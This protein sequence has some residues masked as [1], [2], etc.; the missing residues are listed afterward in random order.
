MDRVQNQVTS[1][2]SDLKEQI[3]QA[4]QEVKTELRTEFKAVLYKKA[5]SLETYV[6][7]R[8]NEVRQETSST[9]EQLK[10]T[11]AAVQERQERMWRAIDGMSKDV[12]EL[13]QRDAGT[14]DE[15]GIEPLPVVENPVKKEPAPV[16]TSTIAQPTP[17]KTI[18]A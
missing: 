7:S 15:E 18:P 14:E 6:E 16:E 9:L 13:V 1:I 2:C 3:D 10:E 11:I 17:E 4:M 8:V 5:V 12:Q